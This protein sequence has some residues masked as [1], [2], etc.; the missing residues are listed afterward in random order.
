MPGAGAMAV[1]DY[2][3]L[4]KRSE[5]YARDNARR[6]AEAESNCSKSRV[7]AKMAAQLGSG[8]IVEVVKLEFVTNGLWDNWQVKADRIIE[9]QKEIAKLQ[10][11]V[12]ETVQLDK[13][14]GPVGKQI[15]ANLDELEI[16][17]KN[18]MQNA[19]ILRELLKNL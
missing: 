14:A 3:K 10:E 5:K 16:V 13:E 15:Q 8:N 9:L 1:E 17:G 12:K 6:L 11:K 18:M 19:K 4:L 7:L 2:K